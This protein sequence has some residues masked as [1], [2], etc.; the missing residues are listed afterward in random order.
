MVRELGTAVGIDDMEQLADSHANRAATPTGQV[1]R[2]LD[3]GGRTRTRYAA[4]AVAPRHTERLA[5]AVA[6][7]GAGEQTVSQPEESR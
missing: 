6:S 3:R 5:I 2:E 4:T 7:R 1:K